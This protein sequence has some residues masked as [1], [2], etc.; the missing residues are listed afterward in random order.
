MARFKKGQSG[1]RAGQLLPFCY[2][3]G[4]TSRHASGLGI[5]TNQLASSRAALR[6]AKLR[7]IRFHDLRHTFASLLIAANVHPKRIQALMGHSTIRIT[8][9]T[10]GHLMRDHDDGATEK[11]AALISGNKVVTTDESPSQKG[12]KSLKEM[13]AG[14][15]I[16]PAYTAL[17]AA[18]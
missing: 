4:N 2:H 6:R 1:N 8:L 14:V 13:E 18:A 9:D 15:G 7:H 3:T 16:E 17:Q 10:Y 11:L 5:T 12:R